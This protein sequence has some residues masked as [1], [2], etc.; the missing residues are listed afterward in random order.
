MFVIIVIVII[1]IMI[2]MI[3]I[4]IIIIRP[5]QSYKN[6]IKMINGERDY[7]PKPSA[8]NRNCEQTLSRVFSFSNETHQGEIRIQNLQ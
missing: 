1:I 8:L 6:D 2:I 5:R 3:I 4:V 7:L